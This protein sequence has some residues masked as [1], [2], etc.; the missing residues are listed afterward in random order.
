MYILYYV[1]F[2][3]PKK[4]C[5]FS[6]NLENVL[7]VFKSIEEAA[8]S[9]WMVADCIWDESTKKFSFTKL[10]PLNKQAVA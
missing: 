3:G 6:A 8:S 7:F 1:L 10:M 5:E 2:P 9:L 4:I